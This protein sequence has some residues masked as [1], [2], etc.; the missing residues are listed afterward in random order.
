MWASHE[1]EKFTIFLFQV[2][3]VVSASPIWILSLY[4]KC[5][6]FW[7]HTYSTEWGRRRRRGHHS[8]LQSCAKLVWNGMGPKLASALGCPVLSEQQH[9]TGRLH[10]AHQRA[11]EYRGT[12]EQRSLLFPSEEQYCVFQIT[13]APR[14][15][16]Y[17][18]CSRERLLFPSRSLLL[19]SRFIIS[20][21]K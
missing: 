10:A 7:F 20:T 13:I 4:T 21:M 9:C 18:M 15:M 8:R 11:H 16:A 19:Q 2:C 3:G 1:R 5:S 6:L 12:L 14:S 17:G